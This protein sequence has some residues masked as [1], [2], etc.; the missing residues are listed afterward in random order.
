MIN[1]GS[2]LGARGVVSTTPKRDSPDLADITSP[3]VHLASCF[4]HPVLQTMERPFACH[5]C[6]GQGVNNG[7]ARTAEIQEWI[8]K[9]MVR[10]KTPIGAHRCNSSQPGEAGKLRDGSGELAE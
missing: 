1:L 5:L 10:V 9:A 7:F 8:G 3:R 6:L 4:S 2:R